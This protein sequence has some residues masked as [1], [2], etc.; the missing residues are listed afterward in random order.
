MKIIKI[1]KKVFPENS[2]T[3]PFKR[4]MPYVVAASSDQDVKILKKDLNAAEKK[5]KKLESNMDKL[6]S[7]IDS[8]NIGQRRFWQ[9]QTIFTSLQR[10]I[11]RFEKIEQEWKKYKDQMD[12]LQKK[13]VENKHRAAI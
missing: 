3:E 9:Q 4:S 10:K 2:I 11:E 1:A 6:T 12:C 5:I 7:K 8:L 13:I